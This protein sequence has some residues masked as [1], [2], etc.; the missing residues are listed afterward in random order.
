MR[1]S[2]N[3]S[4]NGVDAAAALD[5]LECDPSS[6]VW[7]TKGRPGGRRDKSAAQ[8]AREQYEA[9]A[10]ARQVARQAPVDL[11][12]LDS[13]AHATTSSTSGAQLLDMDQGGGGQRSG[14]PPGRGLWPGDV[15]LARYGP[16][17][18]FFRAK[19]VRVYS[20]RGSSLADVEWLRPQAGSGTTAQFV[21]ST[22]MDETLHGVGLQVGV[23]TQGL[24]S[25][26]PSDGVRAPTVAPV[27]AP[28][29]PLTPLAAA[30][31][32]VASKPVATA[33]A[34]LPS[35]AGA[36]SSAS[37]ATVT[38][39]L[40]L[41]ADST[42]DLLG[43]DAVMLSG[44]PGGFGG[45]T[46]PN[47]QPTAGASLWGGPGTPTATGGM[48]GTGTSQGWNGL[49]QWPQQQT[50]SPVQRL[51]SQ[52]ERSFGFVSD[53]ISQASDSSAANMRG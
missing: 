43:G 17:G 21:C 24:N 27:S 14:A 9:Q 44:A 51:A 20:S 34:A 7:P 40:D 31:A 30:A 38:D 41:Q 39:L 22:G 29:P 37:S 52:Q 35:R 3:A 26:G 10:Q 50:Q 47:S 46:F 32:A 8:L 45:A 53:M 11:L 4:S 5:L 12:D 25:A 18:S 19:V 23:D 2:G 28:P 49:G 16:N 42:P 13:P 33:S 48:A 15:I 6:L 36:T 1:R